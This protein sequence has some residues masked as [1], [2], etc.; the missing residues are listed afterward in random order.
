MYHKILVP[1]DG[2]D[3]SFA[4]LDVALNLVDKDDGLIV[5]LHAVPAAGLPTGLE[6]WATEEHVKESPRWL[7]ENSVGQ[8]I[9]E[10]ARQRA[11]SKGF[12]RVEEILGRGDPAREITACAQSSAVDAIVLGTRGLSGFKSVVLGSVA[13]KVLHRAGCAVVAV[14]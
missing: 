13:Q 12:S 5:L 7:Y 8:G 9:L 11:K 2:S 1:V 3:P 4:A 14:H 10:S 6:Q